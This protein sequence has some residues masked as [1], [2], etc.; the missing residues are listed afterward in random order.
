[1]PII[2]KKFIWK[3]F[4]CFFSFI[5]YEQDVADTSFDYYKNLDEDDDN[6]DDDED[7]DDDDDEDDEIADMIMD[8]GNNNNGKDGSRNSYKRKTSNKRKSKSGGLQKNGRSGSATSAKNFQRNKHDLDGFVE[9]EWIEG[10]DLAA[11]PLEDRYN[12]SPKRKKLDAQ[13]LDSEV[14]LD[15]VLNSE[16]E[17]SRS[18]T[19][20]GSSSSA[21][22][23]KS[24]GGGS[25]ANNFFTS[26]GRSSAITGEIRR[27]SSLCSPQEYE[28][29]KVRETPS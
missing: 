23:R 1:M 29:L 2:D 17:A 15:S 8:T 20:P 3:F 27:D 21:D 7:D 18:S 9:T 13:L 22:E 14:D 24:G 26:T 28:I 11:A 5:D 25:A 19:S 16:S 4:C 12:P 6:D 10:E